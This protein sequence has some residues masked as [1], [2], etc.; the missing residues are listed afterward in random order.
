MITLLLVSDKSL[1]LTSN[2]DE[3]LQKLITLIML[4]TAT[5]KCKND[6]A[7]LTNVNPILFDDCM[8][9]D[10]SKINSQIAFKILQ[11]LLK[12]HLIDVAKFVNGKHG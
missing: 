11:N 5:G 8:P 9:A 4:F 12:M 10:C 3:K 7:C 1:L 6:W 2:K